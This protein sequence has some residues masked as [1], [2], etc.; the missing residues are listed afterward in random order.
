[1]L[2][3]GRGRLDEA[4][5]EFEGVAR[6]TWRTDAGSPRSFLPSLIEAYA[7]AGRTEDAR[8][9]L[10]VYEAEAQ[11]TGRPSAIAPALR[12]RG[13]IEADERP[14]LLALAE[15]ER[16]DNPFEQART[17]A[18]YGEFLRRQKRRAAARGQL[19]SALAAFEQ[20][21]ATTWAE[22]ARTELRASGDRARRRE[23]STRG[24]LTPQELKVAG[25]V[26]EGLTNREIAERL[27]LSP[28]TIETHLVHIFQKLHV[29]SRIELALT[30]ARSGAAG[31][32]DIQGFP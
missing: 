6:A 21:G 31:P 27:F 14:F 32:S 20:V 2:E 4:I 24:D 15:H 18:A 11:C 30:L 8:T 23:P 7:R 22:R 25:L 3:L 19:R 5:R 12:C 17:Q 29:R 9:A 16:W 26:C 13:L 10:V 1:M 28:K